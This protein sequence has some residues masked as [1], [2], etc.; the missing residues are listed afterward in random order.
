MMTLL[1]SS[2]PITGV[3]KPLKI[4]LLP[5]YPMLFYSMTGLP[6]TLNVKLSIIKFAWRIYLET[7]SLYVNFIMIAG[8]L[9]K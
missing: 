5:V 8:G 4:L 6:A 2:T 9:L 1:S 3:L 7:Y